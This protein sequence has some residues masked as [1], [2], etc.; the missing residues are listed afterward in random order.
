MLKIAQQHEKKITRQVVRDEDHIK[1][2][3][4]HLFDA[5]KHI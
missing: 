5:D 3:V 1:C 4:E 2:N